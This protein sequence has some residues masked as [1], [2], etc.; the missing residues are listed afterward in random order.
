M[1]SYPK[2]GCQV[3]Q[4]WPHILLTA[5]DNRSD[6][7][8]LTGP[9]TKVKYQGDGSSQE[10]HPDTRR[11]HLQKGGPEKGKTPNC[12]MLIASLAVCCA[13]LTG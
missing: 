1:L 12:S 10:G 8:K 13:G 6:R 11:S 5:H 9:H 4:I 7:A 3:S 2:M